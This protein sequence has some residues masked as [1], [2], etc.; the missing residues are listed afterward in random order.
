[1]KEA[2][3]GRGLIGCYV[4]LGIRDFMYLKKKKKAPHT[5]FL[6]SIS[7][8]S[9]LFTL[10]T[11]QKILRN[12]KVSLLRTMSHACQFEDESIK[13]NITFPTTVVSQVIG[14]AFN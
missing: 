11:W 10:V 7:I 9:L 4:S 12:M 5:I 3:G 6:C 1:M 14:V 13:S 8:T 2:V